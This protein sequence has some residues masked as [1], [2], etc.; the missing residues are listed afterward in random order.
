MDLDDEAKKWI[1]DLTK[2]NMQALYVAFVWRQPQTKID[3]VAATSTYCDVENS[4]SKIVF[5]YVLYWKL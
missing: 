2:D 5:C 3:T 1:F 4:T